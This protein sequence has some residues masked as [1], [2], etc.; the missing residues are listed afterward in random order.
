MLC[1]GIE[2]AVR[3]LS[4]PTVGRIEGV[5][6]QIIADR[7]ND[8]QFS[9]CDMTMRQIKL[10]EESIAKSLCSIYHGRVAYPSARKSVGES[11]GRARMSV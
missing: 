7:L 3:S 1:D 10:V 11:T 8:G 6:H 4:E 5:V 2:S 9:D